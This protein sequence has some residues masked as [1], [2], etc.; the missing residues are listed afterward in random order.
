MD[1][2]PRLGEGDS[3]PAQIAVSPPHPTE[4]ADISVMPS[5]RKR[6]EGHCNGHFDYSASPRI[7]LGCA[8]G[9]TPS[10]MTARRSGA[11]RLSA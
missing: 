10:R 11:M 5:P 7:N 4:C 6:G 9:S 3:R 1:R 8:A 2:Q